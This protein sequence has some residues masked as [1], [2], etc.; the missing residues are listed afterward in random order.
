[1]AGLTFPDVNVWLAILHF[2]HVHHRIAKSWWETD[3]SDAI[4]FTRITQMSL[5]RLLTTPAVM[6]QK[7]LSMSAAWSA[8]DR[9]FEDNRV[10]YI[11]E[12]VDVEAKFRSMTES[13]ISSPKVWADAWLLAMAECYGGRVVTFDQRMAIQREICLVLG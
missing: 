8:Y 7:P 12:P 9:L 13:E 1:M 4:C 6:N 5:L 10:D 11:T 2:E 3:D